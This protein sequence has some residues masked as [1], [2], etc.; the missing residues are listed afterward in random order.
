M[1]M[2]GYL[3][4]PAC[5]C[6]VS[7]VVSEAAVPACC[8]KN[9]APADSDSSDGDA[10]DHQCACVKN[11][12]T[13][14]PTVLALPDLT[15]GGLVVDFPMVFEDPTRDW[16]VSRAGLAPDFDLPPPPSIRQM[17]CVLRL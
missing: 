12:N 6:A 3:S 4:F 17:F 16:I 7:G 9:T 2:V 10:P 13:I 1:I 8:A 11:K 14:A 5:C 15:E